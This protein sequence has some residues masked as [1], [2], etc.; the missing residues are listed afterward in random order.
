MKGRGQ[1]GAPQRSLARTA[2]PLAGSVHMEAEFCPVQL[3]SSVILDLTA[4]VQGLKVD[5]ALALLL[6]SNSCML[7]GEIKITCVPW[8]S[9]GLKNTIFMHNVC[10]MHQMIDMWK[11]C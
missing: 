1:T 5:K 2:A 8:A 9:S 4:C 6:L 3:H 11:G 7:F 10:D